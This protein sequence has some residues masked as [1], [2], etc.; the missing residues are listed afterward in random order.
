MILHPLIIILLN[1]ISYVLDQSHPVYNSL[2]IPIKYYLNNYFNDNGY[3]LPLE[4]YDNDFF[5]YINAVEDP[6]TK[7]KPDLTNLKEEVIR[8]EH[9]IILSMGN[10][11]FWAVENVL[12]RNVKKNL[13]IKE[14]GNI[15]LD[16]ISNTEYP[17]HLPILHNI[18]NL[19]FERTKD[20]II[21]N[22]TNYISYFHYVGVKLGELLLNRKDD[23]EFIEKFIK[24]Y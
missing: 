21:D 12:G 18:A 15:F 1:N 17:I 3:K 23:F 2:I 11:A 4:K 16:R 8:P 13:S 5:Y 6:L 20:F 22:E 7:S 24:Y 19:K 10:F 9:K 14:L